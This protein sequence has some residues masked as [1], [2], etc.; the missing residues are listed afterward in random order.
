MSK[1]TNLTNEIAL[2]IET[3]VAESE[4][5]IIISQQVEKLANIEKQIKK[6]MSSAKKAKDAAENA[7]NTSAGVFHRKAAIENI[8]QSGVELAEAV[9]I[10]ADALELSFKQHEETMQI[11][12]YLFALGVSNIAANR[13]VVRELTLKLKNASEEELSEL[14]RKEIE[15]IIRSLKA[16]EDMENK[17]NNVSAKQKV[18][19]QEIK[20]NKNLIL[21]YTEKDKEQ[22]K[23]ISAQ[24]Q[25]IKQQDNHIDELYQEND[26]QDELINQ[27]AE[28]NK[29]Q[30]ESI[31]QLYQENDTQDELINQNAEDN[32]RQDESIE[33]LYQENDTQDEL[34]NQNA[35][36]N[37]RQ[38]ESIE[39]LYQENDTQDELINQNAEDNK[40]QDESIEKLYQEN[41]TQDDLINKNTEKISELESL[42]NEQK[43]LIDSIKG[44]TNIA[45]AVAVVSALVSIVS[46]VINFI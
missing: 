20:T 13:T 42:L 9:I 4:L 41:D 40:R 35:E 26:Q 30:D 17:I 23:V 16:Q 37:K 32:K 14:A 3:N 11:T 7:K 36:D 5:P 18:L 25:K 24:G 1:T 10:Q 43:A 2:P 22:D 19:Q 38:D 29:R 31:E 44:N 8:Q 45:T 34:I 39:Q 27:N 46:I 33:Q 6:A 21:D 12:K 15:D 28:D